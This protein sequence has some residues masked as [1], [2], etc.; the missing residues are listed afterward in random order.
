M[1][2]VSREMLKENRRRSSLRA[3][4][5]QSLRAGFL[6]TSDWSHEF[7]AYQARLV[8]SHR[9]F[10]A[11][12]F[13]ALGVAVRRCRWVAVP[14][15]ARNRKAWKAWQAFWSVAAQRDVDCFVATTEAAALPSLLFRKVRLLQRPVVVISVATLAPKYTEGPTGHLRRWLLRSA[16]RIVVL[17]SE[18]VELMSERLGVVIDRVTF[19]PFGIDTE[20][21][22]APADRQLQTRWDV[23]GIGTNEGKDYP[24][25]VAALD[26]GERCLIVTDSR[27]ADEVK[28]TRTQ[29]QVTLDHD[30]P[31]LRL[32]GH[33]LDARRIVIPLRDVA[34]SS[35]QTVLLENLAL[36]RPVIV[37]NTLSVRDYVSSEVAEVVPPGDV[38]AMRKALDIEPPTHVPQ[39]IEHVRRHFS[40]ERFANDLANLC[41]H[42]SGAR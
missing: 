37:S 4:D 13:P 26:P 5:K 8:P 30:V 14:S 21:F 39:A 40:I 18:Q 3:S 6:Y 15:G 17:A 2:V 1:G 22:A 9:L 35:G 42:V 33:Y 20:F 19:I 28:R 41:R 10:G 12:E 16:D 38:A 34:F 36:G 27:N 7:R 25:L 32:R 23:A 31:I 11:A 24:T 29:G